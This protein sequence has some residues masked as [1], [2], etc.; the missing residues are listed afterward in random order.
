MNK[1]REGGQIKKNL[2]PLYGLAR[3]IEHGSIA[4]FWFA[5]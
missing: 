1:K 5:N 2:S 4:Q 3:K